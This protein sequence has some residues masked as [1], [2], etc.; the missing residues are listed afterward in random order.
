MKALKHSQS[1][2]PKLKIS[3]STLGLN[4]EKTLTREALAEPHRTV[5]DPLTDRETY[6]LQILTAT[7]REALK[8][9]VLEG[10]R[11]T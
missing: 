6:Q 1:E 3:S 8:K 2:A 11:A 4:P 7:L 5:T 10:A 9:E